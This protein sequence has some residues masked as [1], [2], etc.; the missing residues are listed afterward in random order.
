MHHLSENVAYASSFYW[1]P[2]EGCN[3]Q[4]KDREKREKKRDRML[5]FEART[6]LIC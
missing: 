5:I 3:A 6:A 4:K 1:P 2:Q